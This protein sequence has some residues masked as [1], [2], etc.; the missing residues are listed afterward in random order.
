[1]SARLDSAGCERLARSLVETYLGIENDSEFFPEYES[2]VKS[3]T[4]EI[5]KAAKHAKMFQ[6]EIAEASRKRN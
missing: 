1:M 2:E 4:N 5:I 6:E 3:M